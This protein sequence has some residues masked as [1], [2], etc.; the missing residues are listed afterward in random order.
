MV[1]DFTANPKQCERRGNPQGIT[2]T[3]TDFSGGTLGPILSQLVKS[4]NR[5]YHTVSPLK[6]LPCSKG[7]EFIVN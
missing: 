5:K 1:K 6:M 2:D 7:I 3:L 4:A